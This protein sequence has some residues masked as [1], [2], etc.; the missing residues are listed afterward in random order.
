[1]KL[2]ILVIDDELTIRKTFKMRLSKWGYD[3]SLASDGTSG[4]ELLSNNNFDV[5][6]SDIK[7]PGI[8]GNEL[9]KLIKERFPDIE[10]IVITGFASVELAVEVMKCGVCDFLCKPLD[11]SLIRTLLKRINER[12]Y[13]KFEN[14]LLKES[15]SKLQNELGQKYNLGEI[16]GKSKSMKDLFKLIEAVAPLDSTVLISGETGTGK[17][18]IAKTIHYKSHR[19]SGHIVTVDCGALTETLLESE[20][21][22]HK[23]GAFTGAQSNKRGLF[24]QANGGTIFL[25][26]ISNAS[27]AVQQKLLRLIEEKSFQRLGDESVIKVDVRIIAASNE[28]L[29]QLVQKGKFRQDLF[30]RLNVVP[31]YLPS[32]RERKEDIPILAR[33][34]LDFYSQQLDR[35]FMELQVE[36]ITQLLSHSW[37]GNVRELSNVMERTAILTSGNIIQ[38]VFITEIRS[39]KSTISFAH[40]SL[41]TPLKDQIV[42]LERNYLKLAMERYHGRVN[43][44]VHCS[45][46]NMRTLFRKLRRY[47]LDKKDYR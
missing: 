35:D 28:D 30:Y 14:R 29:I 24:E 34:F 37:P 33:Y 47:N 25:D 43:K 9:V 13:L 4:M 6:I 10:I 2:K 41:D 20:L 7:L 22:G 17:E 12:L 26:E 32:L 44:V 15:I 3:V 1:M 16:V 5:V 42:E 18:L 45:G 31:I 21:F 40:P 23:K 38:K 11:F 46:V 8:P 36:A 39:D 19:A 27:Q